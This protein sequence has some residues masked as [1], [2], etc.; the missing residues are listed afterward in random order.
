MIITFKGFGS[1]RMLRNYQL[2]TGVSLTIAQLR[3]ELK[4]KLASEL[5]TKELAGLI[6]SCAFACDEEL[7]SENYLI[8]SSQTIS[9]L[10]PVCGG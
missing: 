10:P 3:Q 9:I 7:F 4:T 6:D 8:N 2:E 5:P 1:V